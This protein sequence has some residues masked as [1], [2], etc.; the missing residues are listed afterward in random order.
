[1]RN[2]LLDMDDVI[3]DFAEYVL[4]KMGVEHDPW[5]YPIEMD[6]LPW[7]GREDFWN[8]LAQDFWSDL[9]WTRDGKEI[10]QIAESFGCVYLCTC[11]NVFGNTGALAHSVY[12]KRKWIEREIPYLKHQIVFTEHKELLACKHNILIDDR[13]GNVDKFRKSGGTAILVP[14]KY[15]IMHRYADRSVSY[16]RKELNRLCG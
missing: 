10:L 12:G 15:N 1:M 3:C 4:D 5:P 14:R 8:N 16:V 13:Y 9:P 2:I 7:G 11:P 6:G